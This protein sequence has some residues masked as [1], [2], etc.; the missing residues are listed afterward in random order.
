MEF[1]I[2]NLDKPSNKKWKQVADIILYALIPELGIL[3]MLPL[4]E[5]WKLAIAITVAELSLAV[6]V[7]TKFTAE[8]EVIIP[9]E[10]VNEQK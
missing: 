6:K 7:I 4:T 1:K 10:S 3:P 2:S 5:G 8:P 9:Q